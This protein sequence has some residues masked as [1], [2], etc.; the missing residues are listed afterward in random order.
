VLLSSQRKRRSLRVTVTISGKM[1]NHQRHH[2]S[3]E[4]VMQ[5]YAILERKDS[6]LQ[7]TGLGGKQ[8]FRIGRRWWAKRKTGRKC[9]GFNLKA[10]KTTS[11]G[12]PPT[13]SENG[14]RAYD[15]KQHNDPAYS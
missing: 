6:I 3:C 4:T 8:G 14:Q 2:V 9:R 15:H 11:T 7:V 1:V 5:A 10:I 13:T 12:I